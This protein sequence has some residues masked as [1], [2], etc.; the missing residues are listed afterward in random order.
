MN[1]RERILI[2]CPAHRCYVTGSYECDEQGRYLLGPS[3][4]FELNRAKCGQLGGRCF[5]TLCFLHRYNRRGP[6]TWYPTEILAGRDGNEQTRTARK[7][8]A[9]P[10]RGFIA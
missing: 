1:L 8:P 6:G 2:A 5:E 7:N 10:P 4:D 9:A 3:G